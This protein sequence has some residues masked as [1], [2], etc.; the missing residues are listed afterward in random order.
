MSKLLSRFRTALD[1]H[2]LEYLSFVLL[3]FIPLYP[4]IPLADILPGYIVRIRLDDFLV[5]LAFG[6][7]LIWLYRKKV[8]LKGNPLFVPMAIYLII[9]FLSTLSAMFVTK[10]VPLSPIHI[11][12]LYLNYGRR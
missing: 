4:K 10:T 12:K 8:T 11:A 9:G 2:I 3:I 5:A 7:W 1:E 6:I